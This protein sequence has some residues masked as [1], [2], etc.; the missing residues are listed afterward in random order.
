MKI[1]SVQLYRMGDDLA[2][3]LIKLSAKNGKFDENQTITALDMIESA[4]ERPEAI[5]SPADRTP[6]ATVSLLRTVVSLG[7]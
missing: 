7:L 2:V 5:V 4:F 1:G 6:L 3:N